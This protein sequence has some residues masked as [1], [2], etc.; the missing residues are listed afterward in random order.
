MGVLGSEG[1]ADI[2]TFTM[3]N[4]SPTRW[5]PGLYDP[6]LADAIAHSVDQGDAGIRD[7]MTRKDIPIG[8]TVQYPITPP[9]HVAFLNDGE[10]VVR[11]PITS[12]TVYRVILSGPAGYTY[13][14]VNGST[15]DLPPA[16]P[17]QAGVGS[18]AIVA[19]EALIDAW[20][21]NH[22]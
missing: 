20:L 16:A 6:E 7:I 21:L 13:R 5:L 1:A 11:G 19:W 10:Q 22:P 18:P 17:Y 3:G 2:P 9:A 8:V 15:N 12:A 14:L 4:A